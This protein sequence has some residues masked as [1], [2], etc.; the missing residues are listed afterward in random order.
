MMYELTIYV[1]TEKWSYM[2]KVLPD[3]CFSGFV[4][5]EEKWFV[6]AQISPITF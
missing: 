2:H 6:F 3:I 4:K 1:M 5:I